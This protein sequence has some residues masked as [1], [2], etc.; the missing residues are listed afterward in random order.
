VESAADDHLLELG[1]A[2]DVGGVQPVHVGLR[3][4]ERRAV[5]QPP[6]AVPAVVVAIGVR[7]RGGG[8][9]E[10]KPDARFAWLGQPEGFPNTPT[11]VKG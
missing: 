3:L 7:L 11:I 5:A 9:R 8:E 4:L 1:Q 2:F 6:D 10:G